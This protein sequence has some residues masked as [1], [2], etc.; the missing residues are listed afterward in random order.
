ME[1]INGTHVNKTHWKNQLIG[2]FFSQL[3]IKKILSSTETRES[4]S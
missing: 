1:H 2:S 4:K 3:E